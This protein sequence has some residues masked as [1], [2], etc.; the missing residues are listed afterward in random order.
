VSV[1]R[2]LEED[3]DTWKAIVLLLDVLAEE[4]IAEAFRLRESV[5]RIV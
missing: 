2:I 1:H 4:G 5:A 3:Q